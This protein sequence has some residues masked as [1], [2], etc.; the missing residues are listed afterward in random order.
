MFS[1]TFSYNKHWQKEK[2]GSEHRLQSTVLFPHLTIYTSTYF[3]TCFPCQWFL[4]RTG[5]RKHR[6]SGAGHVVAVHRTQ[7]ATV[8]IFRS[9][10]RP[11]EAERIWGLVFSSPISSLCS[12]N[13]LLAS[14]LRSISLSLASPAAPGSTGSLGLEDEVTLTAPGLTP[15]ICPCFP[16]CGEA[17]LGWGEESHPSP[18]GS[19]GLNEARRVSTGERT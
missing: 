8:E 6:W 3:L 9:L 17:N 16:S 2:E 5:V 4:K 15:S 11:Q 1:D 14:C 10:G 18:G 12:W 19:R 13:H 7:R